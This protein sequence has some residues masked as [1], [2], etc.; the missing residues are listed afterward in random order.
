M[1]KLPKA[2]S[3]MFGNKRG[4]SPT[5]KISTKDYEDAQLKVGEKVTIGIK[6]AESSGV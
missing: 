2:L 1:K 5:F 3:N 4:V 6:K